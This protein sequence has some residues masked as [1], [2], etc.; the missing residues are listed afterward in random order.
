[1]SVF[2]SRV[3]YAHTPFVSVAHQERVT[4][5]KKGGTSVAAE[6]DPF[7]HCGQAPAAVT[8]F[9]PRTVLVHSSPHSKSI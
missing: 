8:S 2:H 9:E 5:W 4:V 1:M 7:P 3:V 6:S